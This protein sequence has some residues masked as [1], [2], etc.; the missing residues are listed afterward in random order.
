[1]SR[2]SVKDSDVG[3][4][5]SRKHDAGAWSELRGRLNNI[6]EFSQQA[7]GALVRRARIDEHGDYG[8]EK[9]FG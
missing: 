6:N 3:T 1:M 4:L 7:S 8:R 5:L 2:L 9:G